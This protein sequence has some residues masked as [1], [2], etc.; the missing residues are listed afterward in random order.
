MAED[1]YTTAIRSY[2]ELQPVGDGAS[3]VTAQRA[4]AELEPTGNAAAIVTAQRAYVEILPTTHFALTTSIRSYV[5][6]IAD[7]MSESQPNQLK[8]MNIRI[9]IGI[10]I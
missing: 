10:R 9:G 8:R 4:Y 3:I 7:T 1:I 6:L 2:V 5:E